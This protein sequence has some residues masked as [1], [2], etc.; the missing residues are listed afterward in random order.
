MTTTGPSHRLLAVESHP[1]A[2][3]VAHNFADKRGCITLHGASLDPATSIVLLEYSH[4]LNTA[5]EVV[6]LDM[7]FL[8]ALPLLADASRLC[9]ART[10]RPA[11]ACRAPQLS[12]HAPTSLVST[13]GETAAPCS[14]AQ[15][16]L[17]S[18]GLLE[19]RQGANDLPVSKV[20]WFHA[21]PGQQQRQALLLRA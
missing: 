2:V 11:R 4:L 3:A 21:L 1:G 6:A 16:K 19:E 12:A 14:P 17:P 15:R 10:C 8:G 7:C 18:G 20:A 5:C 9:I 13:N